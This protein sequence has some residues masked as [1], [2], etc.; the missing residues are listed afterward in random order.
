MNRGSV[1][2]FGFQGRVLGEY[3]V[4]GTPPRRLPP[5]RTQLVGLGQTRRLVGLVGA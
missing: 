1:V 3:S 4:L 2:K 5:R